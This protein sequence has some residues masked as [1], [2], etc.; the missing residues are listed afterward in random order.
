[1]TAPSPV[2]EGRGLGM[3]FPG[4]RALS[5]VDFDVRAG[6]VH[7]L[8]GENGAGKSTLVRILSGEIVPSDG[9]VAVDGRARLFT[10]PRDA[11]GAGIA[12]IPQELQLV[13]SLTVAENI[14]LG[15]EAVGAVHL[16]DRGVQRDRARDVLH[17]LGADEVHPDTPVE[18][19]GPGAK[20]LVAI[21]RA[22][23]LRARCLIMDEPTSSLG[24]ADAERLSA[25]VSRLAERGT[26]IVY[27]THKLDEVRRLA[28]RLTV[29]RDGERVT[30]MHAKGVTEDDMVRLMVGRVIA[31]A[32][33]SPVAADARELLRV[34]ALS[35]ADADRPDGYRL[36]NISLTVRRGEIVGLAGLMGAGRSELLLAIA[37]AVE[38]GVSGRLRLDGR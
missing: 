8:L 10:S 24:S 28:H 6:E 29:L 1:M 7:A 4:V 21:A 30:T 35:L 23:A 36:R 2:V 33:L 14:A 19:L 3:Q 38:E 15:H 27:I 32:T 25:L 13:S 34:E 22:L 37:G 11:L 31:P 9:T 12:V 18:R 26:G 17:E 16:V 5:G 20:Q